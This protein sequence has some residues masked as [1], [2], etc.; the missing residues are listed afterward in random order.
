MKTHAVALA[1]LLSVQAIGAQTLPA[2]VSP[3]EQKIRAAKKAIENSPGKYQAYNDLALALARRARETSDVTYYQQADEALKT[4]LR[5][6]PD[7]FE[8]MK[9]QTWILLGQHEFARAREKAQALN[10]KTPDDV[11]IY[12][13]LVDANVELGNYAEAE[14]AAQWMLDIR[15]GNI[16]ALTRAAYLRELFGD[17]EGSIDLMNQA[18]QGTAP[19]ESEDR[20]W[21]L[22][23]IAH[24]KLT[25]GNLDEADRILQVA[26]RLFPGYHY[27]LENLAKVRIAQQKYAEAVDLL[28]Q[29]NQKSPQPESVY[30]LGEA[31]EKAGRSEEAKAAY[32]EFERKA[33]QEFASGIADNANR[34]LVFYYADHANNPSE[35]LRIARSEVA[36][37]HDVFTLDACGWALCVNGQDAEARQQIERALAVGIR[38]AKFLYHAGEIAAKQNDRA[39]ATRY[40]KQSLDLNPRSECSQA[41]R[42]ALATLE[43]TSAARGSH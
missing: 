33:R 25:T 14:K 19:N 29:R 9:T 4:S 34:E 13:F 39:R 12:G 11:L 36:R 43:T 42:E 37:R 2:P 3:A 17:I 32:A 16:P 22:T 8:A 20:A 28:R 30:A 21:I 31:L 26:L 23:Q 15:P 27:A 5:L 40:M 6:A 38:D 1:L 10:K 7:N 41:A 18:Y 24:L 35:A